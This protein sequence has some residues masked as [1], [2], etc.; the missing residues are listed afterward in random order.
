MEWCTRRVD[1]RRDSTGSCHDE[2][3]RVRFRRI[4]ATGAVRIGELKKIC[5][6]RGEH[7]T[8]PVDLQSSTLRII[9]TRRDCCIQVIAII[10]AGWTTEED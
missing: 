9:Q 6:F 3:M 5:G 7:I 2:R 10:I 8:A 4:R 1:T